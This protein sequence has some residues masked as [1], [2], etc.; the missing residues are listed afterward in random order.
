LA[1]GTKEQNS[2]EDPDGQKRA[3][4]TANT[5]TREEEGTSGGPRINGEREPLGVSS[6][7]L[8]K[9]NAVAESHNQRKKGERT[10]T[11]GKDHGVNE[12]RKQKGEKK[13]RRGTKMARTNRRGGPQTDTE[14][15]GLD[16]GK[17]AH[18]GWRNPVHQGKSGPRS[19]GNRKAKATKQGKEGVRAKK[20]KADGR[21]RKEKKETPTKEERFQKHWPTKEKPRSKNAVNK[22]KN[23]QDG[24]KKGLG[25]PPGKKR[26]KKNGQLGLDGG[27]ENPTEASQP[28]L[29]PVRYRM[30]NHLQ[31]LESPVKKKER[32]STSLV[33]G[34]GDGGLVIGT[35]RKALKAAPPPDIGKRGLQNG[36]GNH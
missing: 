16:C 35:L 9:N 20:V 19:I 13:K 27:N 26:K 10:Q 28:A 4:R 32:G 34:K 18:S 5:K 36:Q 8:E 33:Y 24:G 3:P 1:G 12:L 17:V 22:K 21:A 14:K 23:S 2:K 31:R 11:T 30:E 25:E 29:R 7:E 6:S 15:K